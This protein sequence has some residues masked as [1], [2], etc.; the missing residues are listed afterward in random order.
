[1]PIGAGAFYAVGAIMTR[2]ICA[3]ESTTA[4]LVGMFGTLGLCGLLG[5]AV[6][7]LWLQGN[8]YF[9]IGWQA[10]TPRF[11]ALTLMQAVGSLAAVACIVRSYQIAD[12]SYVAIFEYLFLFFAL[13]WGYILF[14]DLPDLFGWIGLV[15]IIG[16]GAVIVLRSA[17][18][19][20]S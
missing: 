15:L 17:K 20:G 14:G 5:V 8:S 12:P 7:E 4:L 18:A 11:L 16:A 3:E 6:T 9:T 1:M 2:R 13:V 19:D 10:F